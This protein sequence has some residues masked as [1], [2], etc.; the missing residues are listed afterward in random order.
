MRETPF[1]AWVSRLVR[2]QRG[3]LLRVARREGLSLEDAFDTVQE[4]LQS[5]LGLPQARA[6]AERDDDARKLLSALVRNIARNRRRRH[7]RS[8]EH[9]P[10]TELAPDGSPGADV[11]LERA[12][13]LMLVLGC[14]HLLGRVQKAVVT[15]RLLEDR[16]GVEAARTLGLT[17]GYVAVSLHRAKEELRDCVAAAV[18]ARGAQATPLVDASVPA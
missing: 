17:P 3:L 13:D 15:L 2:A 16:G 1:L 7:D 6:V 18:A 14:M 11:L 8:R 12:Q 9:V 5:F 10:L 4:A